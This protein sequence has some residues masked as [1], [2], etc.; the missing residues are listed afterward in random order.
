VCGGRGLRARRR[1]RQT[2]GLHGADDGHEGGAAATTGRHG[3]IVAT[4]G[5]EGVTVIATANGLHGG[6]CGAPGS[7]VTVAAHG[8]CGDK[9]DAQAAQ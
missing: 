3:Y 7:M 5:R 8:P 6:S 2:A 1:G 9:E 4:T